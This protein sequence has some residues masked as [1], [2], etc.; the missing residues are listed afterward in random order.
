M[1]AENNDALLY[2]ATEGERYTPEELRQIEALKSF[3]ERHGWEVVGALVER[4]KPTR[5]ALYSEMLEDLRTGK[6]GAII[7]WDAESGLAT[8][9]DT[10]IPGEPDAQW[11]DVEAGEQHLRETD[12]K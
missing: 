6:I 12:P 1:P 11:A 2:M 10:E 5:S 8:V 9:W 7:E 3:A 4:Q